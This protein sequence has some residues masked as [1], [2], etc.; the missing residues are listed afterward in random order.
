MADI[1]L[2][3]LE[4]ATNANLLADSRLETI[5]GGASFLHFRCSV[6]AATTTNQAALT[7]ELPD[8]GIPVDGQIVPAN[9][10]AAIGVLDERTL[11]QWTWPAITGGRFI[12]SLVET[13][14][15]NFFWLAQLR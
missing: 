11:M 4:V 10:D 8:G 7:I 2:T 15:V 3:G 12:I 9:G 14:A 1:I 13:G 6:D 5:P